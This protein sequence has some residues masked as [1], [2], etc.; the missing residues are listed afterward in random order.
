MKNT[1][2]HAKAFGR[3]SELIHEINTAMLTTVTSNGMLRSR[4]MA[5][6]QI[7]LIEGTI[8]FFNSSDSPKSE[9]ILH[10]QEVNLSYSSTEK[11]RYVSVSG[12][13]HIVRNPAK[14]REL[15]K[16]SVK[17]WFPGGIEDP[18]LALLRVDVSSAEYWDSQSSMMVQLYGLAKTPADGKNSKNPGEKVKVEIPTKDLQS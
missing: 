10:K 18:N 9:E 13:A 7:D 3:L 5:T 15:W 8:W 6:Q 11:Q 12:R 2:T 14:T 1:P 17:T 16:P 4:P